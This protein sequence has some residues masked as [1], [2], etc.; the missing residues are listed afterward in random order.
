[1]PAQQRSAGHEM[2]ACLQVHM[3]IGL[4]LD[5][6]GPSHRKAMFLM[7][8]PEVGCA[9][10]EVIDVALVRVLGGLLEPVY[11]GS[12][13]FRFSSSI[14]RQTFQ[15]RLTSCLIPPILN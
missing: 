13:L 14:Y 3:D 15:A 1:M 5:R 10:S 7:A 2:N 6:V 8:L 9:L 4:L 11:K 12:D